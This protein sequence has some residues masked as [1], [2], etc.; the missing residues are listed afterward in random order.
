MRGVRRPGRRRTLLLALLGGGVLAVSA[1]WTDTLRAGYDFERMVAHI[2]LALDP[3]PDRPTVPTIEMT[4]PPTAT[5][6]PAAAQT[7]MTKPGQPTPTP[8][9]RVPL[10]VSVISNPASVFASEIRDTWCSLAGVQIVLAAAG[11]ADTSTSFQRNLAAHEGDWI[12]RSDS[13]DR[14]MGPAAIV[15][16]LAAYGDPGYQVRAY[17]TRAAAL[18]DAAVAI[19]TT[20]R[21]V[22]LMAWYGAHVWVMSGYR[23]DAD[24]RIFPNAVIEGAYVLDPWYPRISTIWGPS[25]PPGTYQDAAEMVRNYLAWKRPEGHYPDR[26]GKWIAVVP[27]IPARQAP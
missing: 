1:I 5:P 16:A 4:L 24:P 17:P 18:R 9:P 11:L 10:D 3:P 8:V 15:E 22:V 20:R 21:P 19:S 13:R 2:Q 27:T 26:D 14:G 6:S 25:D 7:P 23:A 12:S